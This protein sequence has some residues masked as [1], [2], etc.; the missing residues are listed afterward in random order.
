MEKYKQMWET[1]KSK[2]V[3]NLNYYR[4]GEM[5]SITESINGEI[6]WEQ[7]QLLMKKIENDNEDG[8]SDGGF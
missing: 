5:M 8:W 2:V 1:L 6:N 7:M 4:K 3:A